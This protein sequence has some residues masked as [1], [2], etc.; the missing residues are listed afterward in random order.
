MGSVAGWQT[1]ITIGIAGFGIEEW[2]VVVETTRV[3][4]EPRRRWVNRLQEE[5][6]MPGVRG[7]LPPT[8]SDL[9]HKTKEEA[10][11]T[12]ASWLMSWVIKKRKKGKEGEGE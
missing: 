11:R 8:G 4:R 7:G 5:G 9:F 3:G 2:M 12:A 6:K 10:A 1:D